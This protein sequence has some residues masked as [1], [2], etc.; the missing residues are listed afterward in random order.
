MPNPINRNTAITKPKTI[1]TLPP[2]TA[3]KCAKPDPRIA[4][5]SSTDCPLV[6]PKTK[7]G[8]NAA[9]LG[10]VSGIA[11]V[12]PVRTLLAMEYAQ[13]ADPINSGSV[14]IRIKQ[15]LRELVTVEINFTG[16]RNV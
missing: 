7:P 12:S 1:V 15:Q 9:P 16:A 6:S 13:L 14:V 5:A 2:L 3:V 11:C 8:T 10:K 4:A